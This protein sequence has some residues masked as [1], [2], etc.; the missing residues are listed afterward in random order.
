MKALL[1]K[2]LL[3]VFIA[4]AT[5]L[6]TGCGTDDPNNLS[7]MPWDKAAPWEGPLPSNMNQGR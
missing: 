1:R 4:G 3:M 6:L 7:T 5:G 2:V